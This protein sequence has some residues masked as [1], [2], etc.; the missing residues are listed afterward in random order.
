MNVREKKIG[1]RCQEKGFIITSTRQSIFGA[2]YLEQ[3]SYFS[4]LNYLSVPNMHYDKV[5]AIINYS[6]RSWDKKELRINL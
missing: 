3:H 6:S 2:Y 4:L 1:T 5:W